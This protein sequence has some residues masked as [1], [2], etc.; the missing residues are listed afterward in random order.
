MKAFSTKS[1]FKLVHSAEIE[2]ICTEHVMQN[3][4]KGS[5]GGGRKVGDTES[6]TNMEE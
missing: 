2:L 1:D 6:R 5:G 4:Y 3:F